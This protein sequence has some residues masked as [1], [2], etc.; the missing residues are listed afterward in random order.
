M[1]YRVTGPA[2]RDLEEI[3]TYLTHEASPETALRIESKLFAAFGDLARLPSMGHH[4]FDVRNETDLFHVVS[5]Y[6]IVF[7][8]KSD[9][10]TILRVLHG[11]R[12]VAR[13][14]R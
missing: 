11:R 7:R 10:V 14:V 4:R 2:I 9:Q 12:D 8:R 1:R 5:S 13:I 6:L 3:A